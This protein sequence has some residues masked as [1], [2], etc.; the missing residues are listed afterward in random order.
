M[1]T[2]FMKQ[3]MVALTLAGA[4]TAGAAEEG[5]FDKLLGREAA[6]PVTGEEVETA[7]SV[8][9]FMDR[10]VVDAEGK[11][12]GK[13]ADLVLKDRNGG[14]DKAIVEVGGWLDLNKVLLA[15]P[16][17]RLQHRPGTASLVW[18]ISRKDFQALVDQSKD[19][20]ERAATSQH[21]SPKHG[22]SGSAK[23]VRS[24][25]P[26]ARA[27]TSDPAN[28]S[29]SL[30][31]QALQAIQE[32]EKLAGHYDKVSVGKADDRLV[33]LGSVASPQIK[34]HLLLTVKKVTDAEVVD[35]LSVEPR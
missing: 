15:V 8:K 14:F 23:E 19:R 3:Q 24:N 31:R 1:K 25:T 34:N 18:D 7:L 2:K 9:D 33:L 12:L 21:P 20:S 11:H 5:I 4:V 28:A 29:D 22:L 17:D 13:I 26:D 30:V 35:K 10:K 27:A 6:T 16:Y 32:D